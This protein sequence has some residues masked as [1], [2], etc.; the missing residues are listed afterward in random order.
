VKEDV[1]DKLFWR[2][3]SE[4]LIWKHIFTKP[5]YFKENQM[6]TGDIVTFIDWS[7]QLTLIGNSLEPR[8]KDSQNEDFVVVALDCVLP[9]NG[10]SIN[11]KNVNNAIIRGQTTGN[12]TFIQE[13][14]LRPATPKVTEV[15]MAEVCAKFG[16]TVKIIREE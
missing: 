9:I 16:E 13:R 4:P 5:Q 6:K 7:W 10:T 15:T 11:P 2:T 3:Y 14:F 12:I 1:L 8:Y